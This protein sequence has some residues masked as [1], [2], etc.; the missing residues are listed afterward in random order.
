MW[1][2]PTFF[3]PARYFEKKYWEEIYIDTINWE[4]LLIDSLNT[5]NAIHSESPTP[6]KTAIA[7]TLY[8]DRKLWL[9][10]DGN[11]PSPQNVP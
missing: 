2:N 1:D 8:F 11:N 10:P 5:N 3:Y 7:K 4:K 6:M 9:K